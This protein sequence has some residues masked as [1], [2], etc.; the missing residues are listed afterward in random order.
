[1]PY[2]AGNLVEGFPPEVGEQRDP[3]R[4]R[5][6]PAVGPAAGQGTPR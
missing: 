1:M 3:A 2:V 4:R 5:P 6:L